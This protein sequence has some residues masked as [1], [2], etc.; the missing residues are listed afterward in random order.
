MK[1]FENEEELWCMWEF[2][3]DCCLMCEWATERAAKLFVAVSSL[4]SV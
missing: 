4:N 2:L 3:I 1:G